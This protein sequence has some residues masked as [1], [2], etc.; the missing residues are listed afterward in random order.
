MRV[1][2][3]FFFITSF[4]WLTAQTKT[5]V[6]I[7]GG[8]HIT[9]AWMDHTVFG[10]SAD[11]GGKPGVN[12]GIF[13]KHFPRKRDIFFNAGIQ[14]GVN[15]VQK[16]WTQNFLESGFPKY[17]VSMNYLEI[18]I[19]GIGYFGNKNKYFIAAGFFAEY[20]LSHNKDASPEG[21][22]FSDFATYV[23]SRDR[24]IGYGGRVSGGVFRDFPF[25][26]LHLEGFF[27]YSFSNFIDAGDLS[28]DQLP[29]I[30][31]NWNLGISIGYLIPF[32]KLE[33]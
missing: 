8:G 2:F 30:S 15:F 12:G 4:L 16:G 26:Q 27:S 25:G 10:F 20:L 22:Q 33:L 32:G 9:S 28:N 17:S 1:V 18:P 6:G 11:L 21:L 29:D 19:E 24:E 7:R 23:P 3:S 14:G 31:N 5:Y 13:V